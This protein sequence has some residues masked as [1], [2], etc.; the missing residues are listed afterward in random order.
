MEV[1]GGNESGVC[2]M[3]GDGVVMTLIKGLVFDLAK[4]RLNPI[5]SLFST[6]TQFGHFHTSLKV[7]FQLKT[8]INFKNPKF[9]FNKGQI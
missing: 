5:L 2:W 8:T 7:Y 3:S 4:I 9:P 6:E 1:R